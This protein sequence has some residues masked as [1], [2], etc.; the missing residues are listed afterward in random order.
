MIVRKNVNH[1]DETKL[2]IHESM[3]F[4]TMLRVEK[5]RHLLESDNAHQ[6]ELTF[7]FG[8][9]NLRSTFWKMQKENHIIDAMKIQ[10]CIDYLNHKWS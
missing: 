1:I 3:C 2:D 6:K 7:S 4:I 10:Q 9:D 5:E 8:N